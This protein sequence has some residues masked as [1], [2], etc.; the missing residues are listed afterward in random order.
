MNVGGSHAK[1]GALFQA[2]PRA[3]MSHNSRVVSSNRPGNT[4]S[5][6][7]WPPERVA[8]TNVVGEPTA[9]G[10]VTRCLSAAQRCC[11]TAK[12]RASHDDMA[13]PLAI[14]EPKEDR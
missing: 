10:R 5:P 9:G 14:E 2:L 13:T 11:G 1:H 3:L 4:G 12:R 8:E 7:Q 6:P